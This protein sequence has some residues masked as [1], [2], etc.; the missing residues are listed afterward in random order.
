MTSIYIS[1]NRET[2]KQNNTIGE[3]SLQPLSDVH[4]N[5]D[6]SATGTETGSYF[7]FYFFSIVGLIIL[8]IALVN[9]INLTTARAINRAKEGGVRKVL[10]ASRKQLLAQNFMLM[11]AIDGLAAT[12][13]ALCTISF[14]IHQNH[15]S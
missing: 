12:A 5:P 6:F 9:Y 14:Q 3:L 8:L 13:I 10:G 1:A 7:S 11:F 15:C 4:L 2:W